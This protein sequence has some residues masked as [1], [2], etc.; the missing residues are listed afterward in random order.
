MKSLLSKN[1]L[2]GFLIFV[3]VALYFYFLSEYALN[4]PKWD[5]HALKAFI[6]EFEDAKG[7]IPKL[8]SFFKQHNEHRI[9]LDRL[10]T[11][12]VYKIHGSIEYR[13]LMWIGNLTLLGLLLIFYR[14]FQKQKISIAYFVPIPF[15]LFQLQ[16]WENTF[17][18]MAAVQNFAIIFLIFGLIYLITS[19]KRANFRLALL[20][21]FLATFTSGNGITVFPVCIL[22]LIIQRKFKD[23]SIFSAIS[24]CLILLYFYHYKFPTNNPSLAGIG[25]NSIVKGFFMFLGSV[26]DLMPNTSLNQ[27]LTILGGAILLVIGLIIAIYLIF[28]SKLFKKQRNLNHL[29]LFILGCLLFLIGTAIL[30]TFTRISYGEI[31]MLTSRY[32]IYS[33]LLLII[34]YVSFISK[35]Q[36]VHNRWLPLSLIFVAICFNFI[37]NFTNF[38]EVVNFKNQLISFGINWELD[39][40]TVKSSPKIRLYESPDLGFEKNIQEIKTPIETAPIWKESIFKTIKSDGILIQNEKSIIPNHQKD[41]VSIIVQSK[42]RTYLMPSQFVNYPVNAFVRTGRYWQNGFIAVLNN[43]EFENGTYQLGIFIKIGEKVQRYSLNDSLIINNPSTKTLK[44]NW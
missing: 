34:I 29:K 7:L 5:D 15:I 24:I 27:N 1:I 30:V 44:T 22:L 40:N 31:G 14:I 35:V 10:F 4:I 23:A 17:W 25:I 26:F 19:E 3:P 18:G 36:A 16:L 28:N 6:V 37:A 8:Q 2:W 39:E 12:I 33:I 11:L 43:N 42:K 20:F 9:A 32:K 41:N 21:A 13:W 38:K